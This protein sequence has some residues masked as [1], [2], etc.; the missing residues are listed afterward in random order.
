MVRW[1]PLNFH[2]AVEKHGND[3][4]VLQENLYG[5]AKARDKVY[6]LGLSDRYYWEWP[7]AVS[8]VQDKL[9]GSQCPLAITVSKNKGSITEVSTTASV[10]Y[11]ELYWVNGSW[12]VEIFR[13][14]VWHLLRVLLLNFIWNFSMPGEL[15]TLFKNFVSIYFQL[16]TSDRLNLDS[17]P[18]VRMEIINNL[19]VS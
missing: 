4:P 15:S 13:K 9:T 10:W 1:S 3:I 7:S 5:G 2:L 8:R 14:E 6:I 16:F 12:R 11:C 19:V 18:H 17:K